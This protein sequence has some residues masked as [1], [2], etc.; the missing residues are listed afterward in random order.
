MGKEIKQANIEKFMKLETDKQT[1]II[2]AAMKEFRYGYKKAS[3]DMIVKEAGISKGLLFHYFGTKE[4]LCIFLINLASDLM[5]RDFFDM[6][7]LGNRDILE[8]FWQVALLQKVIANRHPFLYD[9]INGIYTHKA[10]IPNVEITSLFGEKQQALLEVMYKQSDISLFRDDIDH[11]KAIVIINLTMDAVIDEE[12][13]KAISAG[14]WDGDHYENFLEN[15]KGY[16]DIFRLCF[17]KN[18][19]E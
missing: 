13:I 16:L 3:T 17:Y 7:N 11:K 10:N 12:D 6:M 14:G 5:Q 2:N 15:L 9:F 19:N 8:S 4:Q 18:Q 1:R